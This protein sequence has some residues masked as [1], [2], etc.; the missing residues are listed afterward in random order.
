M[1][2]FP[3]S[4]LYNIN[5]LTVHLYKKGAAKRINLITVEKYIKKKMHENKI[6]KIQ[7]LFLIKFLHEIFTPSPHKKITL[8][9]DQH[10]LKLFLVNVDLLKYQP[11]HFYHRTYMQEVKY[12]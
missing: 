11:P 8:P 10:L 3:L 7:N 9:N 6:I 5:R 12:K 1:Y 4:L 2:I